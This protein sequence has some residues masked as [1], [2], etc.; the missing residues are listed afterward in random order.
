MAFLFI[1]DDLIFFDKCDTSVMFQ[2]YIFEHFP[3][4][5]RKLN[6][7]YMEEMQRAKNGMQADGIWRS[8][9]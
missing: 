8:T 7:S 4:F 3:T 2:G 5:E 1:V 9:G 6:K